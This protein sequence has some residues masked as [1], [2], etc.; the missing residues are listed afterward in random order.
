MDKL[1]SQHRALRL[2]ELLSED[3][4]LGKSNKELAKAVGKTHDVVSRDLAVLREAGWAEQLPSRNWR[5]THKVG[6]LAQHI[7]QKHQEEV[8][9][10]NMS[11]KNYLGGEL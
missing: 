2:V 9:K 11:A 4:L 8:L 3:V 6:H 1:N 10:I 7:A 5:V